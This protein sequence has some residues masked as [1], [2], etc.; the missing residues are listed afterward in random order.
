M[1]IRNNPGVLLAITAIIITA[2]GYRET[3]HQYKKEPLE[4]EFWYGLEGKAAKAVE[5]IV[6]SFNESQDDY[7]V[8]AVQQGSQT[9]TAQ[10]LYATI[11]NNTEPACLILNYE[12]SAS[13][14]LRGGLTPLNGLIDTTVDF[15]KEDIYQIFLKSAEKDGEYYGVPAF[16]S[17]Q[18]LY[19]RKD[20]YRDSGINMESL[21]S[22]DTLADSTRE[23]TKRDDDITL[24]YGLEMIQPKINL[25]DAAISKGGVFLTNDGR[26]VVV[27]SPEWI[28][29]WEFIRK[30]IFVDKTIKV[31]Y[32]GYGWEALFATIDDVMHGRSAG[33]IGSSGDLL[34]LYNPVISAH[35]LPGWD[36]SQGKPAAVADIICIPRKVS[37]EKKRGA[38]QFINYFIST[39][40][41]ADFS[42]KTGYIPVRKSVLQTDKYQ[43]FLS[44][45]P[46]ALVSLKQL[47]TAVP[48]FFDPTGGK[49][50][51]ILENAAELLVFENIPA[52]TVLREAKTKAQSALDVYLKERTGN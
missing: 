2:C 26:T 27:D 24:V 40:N 21:K 44:E 10:A 15:N 51:K 38:F 28:E 33:C 35:I 42:I 12:H 32:G 29:A 19:Y 5:D 39:S 1:R 31:N 17:T 52:E 3:A 30:S 6:L 47:E 25:I 23:L 14:Y 11:I 46:N 4:I 45:N 20:M 8:N 34:Y 9:E 16:G 22:W 18:I 49:I 37:L 48:P 43:K 50:N 7:Y 41:T 36:G 13:L